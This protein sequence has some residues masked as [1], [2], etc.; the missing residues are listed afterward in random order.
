MKQIRKDIKKAEENINVILTGL[1]EKYEDVDFD[2]NYESVSV[3]HR[4][5]FSAGTTTQ[6]GKVKI[7]A[8]IK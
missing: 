7:T 8:S 6:L 2:L 1:N 5:G 4:L 3:K